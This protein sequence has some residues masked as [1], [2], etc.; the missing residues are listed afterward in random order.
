MANKDSLG[1][2]SMDF[3]NLRDGMDVNP[4]A[5]MHKSAYK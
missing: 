5:P 1:Y 4:H 3:E 2:N